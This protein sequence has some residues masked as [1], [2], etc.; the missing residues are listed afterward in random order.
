[1]FCRWPCSE[2]E[3]RTVALGGIG[4]TG[5]L[6][7]AALHHPLQNCAFA[8]IL[9]L[10]QASS[11]FQEAL[12]DAP[13]RHSVQRGWIPLLESEIRDMFL[14]LY[15]RKNCRLR[16]LFPCSDDSQTGWS[17]PSFGLGNGRSRSRARLQHAGLDRKCESL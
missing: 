7:F 8:E 3:V 15:Y 4:G 9:D 1:M 13:G 14:R 11:E 17:R 6:G 2:L 12:R 5:A 10:L 16:L